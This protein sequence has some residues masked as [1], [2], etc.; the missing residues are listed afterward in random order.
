M[1]KLILFLLVIALSFQLTAQDFRIL[2]NEARLVE[3]QN[4]VL[5]G[6]PKVLLE[7]F[8]AGDIPAYY[9]NYVKAQVSFT[10]MLNYAHMADPTYR[11]GELDCPGKFCQLSKNDLLAFQNKLEFLEFDKPSLVGKERNKHIHYIRLK[12]FHK[13]R[14]YNGP[15]FYYKD[16]VKL[17]EKYKLYNPNND[18]APFT[19]KKVLL[20]RMFSSKIIKDYNNPKFDK[21]KKPT[22]TTDDDDFEY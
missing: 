16:I 8:C 5:R 2:L 3:K 6:L 1:K 4:Q 22:I 13:G 12:I 21:D 19:I 14:F 20:S 17:G 10:E 9:P 18:A 7:A 11:Q 15:V